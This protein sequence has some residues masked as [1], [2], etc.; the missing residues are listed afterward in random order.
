VEVFGMIMTLNENE[1]KIVF[2][3]L[4]IQD[5]KKEKIKGLKDLYSKPDFEYGYLQHGAT[6]IERNTPPS[7]VQ[8]DDYIQ[9][10]DEHKWKGLLDSKENPVYPVE[11]YTTKAKNTL[12]I[13]R[14]ILNMNSINCVFNLRD[15]FINTEINE[16]GFI[17]NKP[18]DLELITRKL[19]VLLQNPDLAS[20]MLMDMNL[21]YYLFTRLL[22]DVDINEKVDDTDFVFRNCK[23]FAE[24]NTQIL[25]LSREFAKLNK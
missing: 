24:E 13:I 15:F 2:N 14:E 23:D 7:V 22:S 8:T 5:G 17:I 25:K 11:Y 4:V 6:W 19:D 1:D 10:Y 9:V 20:S 21:D 12:L 18:F 3:K 16:Q